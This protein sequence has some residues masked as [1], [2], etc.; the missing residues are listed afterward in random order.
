MAINVLKRPRGCFEF[1]RGRP[2]CAALCQLAIAY[3]RS[4]ALSSR[5]SYDVSV[6]GNDSL[7]QHIRWKC[8]RRVE[9]LEN[10][11]KVIQHALGRW[12]R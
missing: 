12:K 11:T 3:N 10:A 6:D 4:L 1:C 2:M 5:G 8:K 9:L 7:P